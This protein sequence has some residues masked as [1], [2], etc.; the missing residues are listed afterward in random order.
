MSLI[1]ALDPA[2]GSPMVYGLWAVLLGACSSRSPSSSRLHRD[3]ASARPLLRA[4]LLYLPAWLTVTLI[5]SV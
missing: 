5:V 1:P 3:E 2:S 4:T